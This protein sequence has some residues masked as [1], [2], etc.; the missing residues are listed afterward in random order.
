MDPKYHKF[1]EHCRNGRSQTGAACICWGHCEKGVGEASSGLAWPGNEC[2]YERGTYIH[3]YKREKKERGEAIMVSVH[4]NPPRGRLHKQLG[5]FFS[6]VRQKDTHSRSCRCTRGLSS[7]R[8]C[9]SGGG[10]GDGTSSGSRGQPSRC[11]YSRRICSRAACFGL[12][13]RL[14]PLSAIL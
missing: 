5:C 2:C 3:T 8:R 13:C 9:S 6:G 7:R 14:V 4:I 11:R 1:S 12:C 10:W